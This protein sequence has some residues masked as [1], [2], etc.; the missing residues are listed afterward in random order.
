MDQSLLLNK[1]AHSAAFLVDKAD[2]IKAIIGR[3][4]PTVLVL[5]K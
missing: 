1:L 3:I 4:I 2:V 5:L